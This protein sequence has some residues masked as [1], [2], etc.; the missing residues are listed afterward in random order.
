MFNRRQ[1]Y[2]KK[3]RSATHTEAASGT[4]RIETQDPSWQQ[5]FLINEQK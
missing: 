2:V 1:S 3:K 5:A 4:I